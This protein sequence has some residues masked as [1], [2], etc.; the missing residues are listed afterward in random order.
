MCCVL[1]IQNAHQII[2][3]RAVECFF[4]LLHVCVGVVLNLQ[5][6]QCFGYILVICKKSKR[7]SASGSLMQ[8]YRKMIFMLLIQGDELCNHTVTCLTAWWHLVKNRIMNSWVIE[9]CTW[10][11]FLSKWSPRSLVNMNNYITHTHTHTR[12]TA[13]FRDYPGEPVSEM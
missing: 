3:T 13:L 4:K 2:Y 10:N 11:C 1:Y 7:Y 5:F 8:V 9:T 12:L 6:T